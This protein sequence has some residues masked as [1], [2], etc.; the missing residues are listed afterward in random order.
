[1]IGVVDY[2]AG[3]LAS[4]RHALARVDAE[5]EVFDDPAR[6]VRFDRII[7]PGVGS[8]RL[9]MES[10]NA[11]GWPEALRAHV[12]AGRPLL[13]I[14]L[15]MQLLFD[16]GHEHGV[17]P[18]I[19]LIHG[20]VRRLEL[21]EP[22]KVPHV[23]WNSLQFARQHPLFAGVKPHLD[24]YFV[25]SY[26][27]VP[28]DEADVVARSDHGGSFVACAAHGSAIGIQCHPEKSQPVGLRLLANFAA[29]DGTC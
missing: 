1:M 2:G 23:G 18:G 13:G 8:F 27:C 11:R 26:H 24:F 14:C 4:V 28:Q 12:A 10:L 17:T 5:V 19:G 3:N 9:A 22:H 6:A 20:E 29:W 16:Q 21:P 15:G 7:L 25:H